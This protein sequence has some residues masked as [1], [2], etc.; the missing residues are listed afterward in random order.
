MKRG[1]RSRVSLASRVVAG[2]MAA[3]C[4]IG[5][6]AASAPEPALAQGGDSNAEVRVTTVYIVRHSE[7]APMDDPNAQQPPTLPLSEAGKARSQRLARMLNSAELAAVYATKT[8][9]AHD[10]A[11]PAADQAG[12]AVSEYDGNTPELLAAEVMDKHAGRAVLV[13]GHTNTIGKALKAFGSPVKAVI[14][15]DDYGNIY[16]LSVVECGGRRSAHV[17]RMHFPD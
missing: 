3:A 9:R 1:D 10:T 14:P 2:V 11:K 17:Q 12:V 4:A 16:V 15:D 5:L 6:L 8:T 7:K 13:V